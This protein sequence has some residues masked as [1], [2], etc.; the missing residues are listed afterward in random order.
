MT[1]YFLMSAYVRSVPSAAT[2]LEFSDK[3]K[4][5]FKI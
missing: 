2:L 4:L 1:A 5:K 3:M